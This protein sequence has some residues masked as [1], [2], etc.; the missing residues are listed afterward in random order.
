MRDRTKIFY[1]KFSA[2]RDSEGSLDHARMPW[3]KRGRRLLREPNCSAPDE[4]S[5]HLDWLERFSGDKMM[6]SAYKEAADLLVEALLKGG[7]GSHPDRFAFPILY[8]YRHA[9]ELQM[10]EIIRIGLRLEYLHDSEQ[11]EHALAAHSLYTI[12]NQVKSILTQHWPDAD[13]SQLSAAE[14]IVND[15]HQTDRDGQHLRYPTGKDNVRYKCTLPDRIDLLN[16]RKVFDGFWA[17]LDGS[18]DGLI[19][20]DDHRPSNN[21]D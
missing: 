10:K 20:A 18:Q 4:V 9:A 5:A 1:D 11:L 2:F 3:P 17:M 19:Y 8:L 7:D 21:G 15:L 6:P 16:V 14:A 12:W 13:E